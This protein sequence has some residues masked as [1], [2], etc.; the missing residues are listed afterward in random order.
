L[1][2]PPDRAE[3]AKNGVFWVE[4]ERPDLLAEIGAFVTSV[5]S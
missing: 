2:T 1:P 3:G 4:R 5:T